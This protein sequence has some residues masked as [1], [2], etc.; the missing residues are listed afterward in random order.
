MK[1]ISL[2]LGND[3]VISLRLA[4]DFFYLPWV[5]DTI[6][7]VRGLGTLGILVCKILRQVNVE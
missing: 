5:L 3:K 4:N 1:V 7:L 6:L 2:R